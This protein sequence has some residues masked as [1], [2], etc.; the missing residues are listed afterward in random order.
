MLQKPHPFIFN[1]FSVGLPVVITFFVL[2]ILRPFEFR[3]F[4][5]DGLFVWSFLFSAVVGLVVFLSTMLVKKV[6]QEQALE[7]WTV[8]KELGLVLF[9]LFNISIAFFLLFLALNPDQNLVDLFVMVVIRTISIAIFPLIVLVLF[10]QNHHQKKK[11]EKAEYL[12]QQLL[13]N[14][15]KGDLSKSVQKEGT[16][17]LKVYADN[18]KLILQIEEASFLYANSEGN[19]VDLYYLDKNEVKKE[20]IRLS[21]KALETQFEDTLFFRCHK[22]FI[23]NLDQVQKIEGNA[24]NLELILIATTERIPVSRT[25]AE[26]LTERLN[27]V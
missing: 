11:R 15:Q 14:Q 22:S 12:H 23:V 5:T 8:V 3:G 19:Y 13:K 20:V 1:G 21:L 24:R 25:K 18:N 26:L 4:D 16:K 9:V 6:L 10:E 2:L 7:Q 27:N 17:K